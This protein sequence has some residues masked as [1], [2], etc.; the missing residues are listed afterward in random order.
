MVSIVPVGAVRQ[1]DD[2]DVAQVCLAAGALGI[3]VEE[4]PHPGPKGIR[5]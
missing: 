1:L 5:P 4:V 3:M 2:L